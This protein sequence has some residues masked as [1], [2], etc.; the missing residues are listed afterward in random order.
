MI[1][2]KL[3]ILPDRVAVHIYYLIKRRSMEA[4]ILRFAHQPPCVIVNITETVPS[5]VFAHLQAK[6]VTSLFRDN[7]KE[8]REISVYKRRARTNARYIIRCNLTTRCQA[9]TKISSQRNSVIAI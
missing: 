9:F 5:R 7:H 1:M 8:T 2:L 4:R 6:G 3:Q